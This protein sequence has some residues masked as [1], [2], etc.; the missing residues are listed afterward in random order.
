MSDNLDFIR[1]REGAIAVL[2]V[3]GRID[4]STSARFEQELDGVL[5]DPSEALVI[6]LSAMPYMSSA[7]LRVLLV[8]GRRCKAEG[9]RLLLCGLVPNVREV[10]HMSGFSTIFEIAETRGEATAR[11]TG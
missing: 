2:A 11:L 8:T 4:S 6:D 3:Q 7:G 10:F 9:R 5:A 1:E